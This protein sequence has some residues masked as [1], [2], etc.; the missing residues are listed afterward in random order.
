MRVRSGRWGEKAV[1]CGGRRGR[2]RRFRGP[3][4]LRPSTCRPSPAGSPRCL[5]HGQSQTSAEICWEAS[6]IGLRFADR[7]V[8]AELQALFLL[9]FL[10]LTQM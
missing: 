3:S 1:S 6:R 7:E 9:S 10:P 2:T 8:K 5:R 4:R